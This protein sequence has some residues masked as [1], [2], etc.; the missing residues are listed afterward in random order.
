MESNGTTTMDTCYTNLSEKNTASHLQ[1]IRKLRLMIESQELVPRCMLPMVNSL[2]KNGAV[3]VTA[4][5]LLD[6]GSELHIMN[7]KLYKQLGLNRST[8][9]LNIVGVGGQILRR[10]VPK[11]EV[12]IVDQHG[13]ETIECVVLENTCGRGISIPGD[14]INHLE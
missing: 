6:S 3:Q 2:V 4:T 10:Q 11:I 13:N 12:V 14:V 7:T 8:I 1:S 5:T 9:S